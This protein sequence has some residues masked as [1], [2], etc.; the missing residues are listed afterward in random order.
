MID[1]HR[2]APFLDAR[3]IVEPVTQIGCGGIGC[4]TAL[5]LACMGFTRFR[6]FDGDVVASENVSTQL[7]YHESVVGMNK[8]KV[9]AGVVARKLG[10][11]PEKETV[12]H[13]C[14]FD[15]TLHK[16]L[17]DGIVIA[18]VD[19]MERTAERPFG[20]REIWE[21]VRYHP[22]VRLFLDGRIGGEY[23][24]LYAVRPW[25]FRD[26]LAYENESVLFPQSRASQAACA[27]GAIIYVAEAMGMIMQWQIARLLRGEQPFWRIGLKMRNLEFLIKKEPPEIVV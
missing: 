25:N 21:A 17:L 24:E 22:K 11:T 8:A 6:F 27:Q 9:L 13:D 26:V 5:G 4:A 3:K 23:L 1:F 18:G 14:M 7:L 16:E 15:P 20:R 10:V 19:S 2:Q 12:V